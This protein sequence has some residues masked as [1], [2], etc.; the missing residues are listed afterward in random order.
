MGFGPPKTPPLSGVE[1]VNGD[2]TV[3]WA[4]PIDENPASN[5]TK[6]ANNILT[7]IKTAHGIETDDLETSHLM[8]ATTDMLPFAVPGV[9]IVDVNTIKIAGYLGDPNK[10]L[11][12][13]LSNIAVLNLP[14]IRHS[15]SSTGI[16]A[17]V[18]GN[19][20]AEHDDISVLEHGTVVSFSNI[21]EP[22]ERGVGVYNKPLGEINRIDGNEIAL[23][24]GSK[25]IDISPYYFTGGGGSSMAA[26]NVTP[27]SGTPSVS[28]VI[29]GPAVNVRAVR[30]DR[31]LANATTETEAVAI[32][33]EMLR[34]M[35]S[36]AGPRH[37]GCFGY[38]VLNRL[39]DDDIVICAPGGSLWRPVGNATEIAA[40]RTVAERLGHHVLTGRQIRDA[41]LLNTFGFTNAEILEE[42][43]RL[44]ITRRLNA[45]SAGSTAARWWRVG[46][47]V[48]GVVV[49]IGLQAGFLTV[50]W[51]N[52]L[53]LGVRYR[54]GRLQVRNELATQ[55]SHRTGA[56]TKLYYTPLHLD[57]PDLAQ[58]TLQSSRA[59]T[60]PIDYQY[61]IADVNGNVPELDLTQPSMIPFSYD[62]QKL[63]DQ[64]GIIPG[65]PFDIF[66]CE[67][68]EAPAGGPN[69]ASGIFQTVL[70][71]I[72]PPV[73]QNDSVNAQSIAQLPRLFYLNWASPTDS[74]VAGIGHYLTWH[75]TH[76]YC[77]A[78]PRRGDLAYD[79]QV[80]YMT[81]SV[82]E[83]RPGRYVW[84]GTAIPLTG[85]LIINVPGCRMLWNTHNQIAY[86]DFRAEQTQFIT[87]HEAMRAFLR[88]GQTIR[89]T[90]IEPSVWQHYFVNP[91]HSSQGPGWFFT[92]PFA[93]KVKLGLVG[94]IRATLFHMQSNTEILTQDGNADCSY[95]ELASE[96]LQY[97][98]STPGF[99]EFRVTYDLISTPV[100]KQF[101]M[102][103]GSGNYY[104]APN[105]GV[106]LPEGSPL[107]PLMQ[108][109]FNN[110]LILGESAAPMTQKGFGF[111]GTC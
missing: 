16:G 45:V 75:E 36:N 39:G 35:R 56:G 92:K 61:R 30:W 86:N 41:Q 72:T 1:D 47:V 28:V 95:A 31:L 79:G 25:D 18:I 37:L 7:V 42:I 9:T 85:G 102:I 93:G 77:L 74:R 17:I 23:G 59:D 12:V 5:I 76:G 13:F 62:V 32:T 15:T 108:Q 97:T 49:S 11:D 99:N 6:D 38:H 14:D 8:V 44:G 84:L 69:P 100:D 24:G 19:V 80:G 78:T 48:G 111:Q 51:L 83:Q 55:D 3:T 107:L 27:P 101:C 22:F 90:F 43:Y 34:Q 71:G 96:G 110:A 98:G 73:P 21:V 20:V 52:T 104:Y 91:I 68:R 46:T 4:D 94:P 54:Q 105:V 89:N 88:G 58:I 10:V 2:G 103:G 60:L 64:S 53:P 67:P 63:E 29:D 106:V 87:L 65:R 109:A 70:E 57:R 81:G 82:T 33:R 26:T 66:I 50:D 40:S